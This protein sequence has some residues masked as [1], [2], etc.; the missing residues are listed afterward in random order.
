[1]RETDIITSVCERARGRNEERDQF[2]DM[3]FITSYAL[4][5]PFFSFIDHEF[6]HPGPQGARP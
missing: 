6:S 5:I 2:Q 1:M 3:N 4:V